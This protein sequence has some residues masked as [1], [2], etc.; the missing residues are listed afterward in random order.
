MS[1]I[2]IRIRIGFL[3]ELSGNIAIN[4]FRPLELHD[5]EYLRMYTSLIPS[6]IA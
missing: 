3:L 1:L 6:S 2:C 4:D 5:L